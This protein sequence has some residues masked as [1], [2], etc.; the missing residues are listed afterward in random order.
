MVLLNRITR[1][2]YEQRRLYVAAMRTKVCR[3]YQGPKTALLFEET[4]F[5][6]YK[7]VLQKSL[8]TRLTC[9]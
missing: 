1:D 6:H 8:G 9:N 5:N 4:E 3:P 2:V 7:S